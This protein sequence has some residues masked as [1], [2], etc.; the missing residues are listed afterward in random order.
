MKAT[1][2]LWLILFLCTLPV[3]FGQTPPG[4]AGAVTA[5]SFALATTGQSTSE[6]TASR[7]SVLSG[8]ARD[9][10][11]YLS[12]DWARSNHL[13]WSWRSETMSGGDYANTAEI[14]FLALSWLAAY[15][16][17]QPWQPS[18][19]ETEAEVAAILDQLRAWQTG[20]QT[21]RP[22]GP[23]AYANSVF[24][25]WYWI[26][27]DPPVVSGNPVDHL[28]PSIDNAWLAASLIV[29]R[30]YALVHGHPVLQE[31]ADAI[32]Q[33]MDFRLWYH[34]DSH[35]FTW[36]DVEEP[37]GGFFADYYS[38]ENRIINFM[39]RALGQM[40]REEYKAS[41]N[42]LIRPEGVYGDVTVAAMAWDGSYFTYG[43]PALF[44]REM[45]TAYG[46]N[47][48]LPAAQAQVAYAA[49]QG[50]AAWGLS[51]CYDVGEGGYVQQGAPPAAVAEP[52][53]RPG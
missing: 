8:L 30:E 37:Q 36:G 23:N 3:I 43:G 27:W 12:S 21:Q 31:K 5:P 19:E 9:T 53:T 38:N 29:I 13:P 41:L 18:W 45:E 2:F 35:L 52:E 49:N 7:D 47:T 24:Y 26:G 34:P 25:Q 16:M 46:A 40:T 10:W 44:I 22:H 6:L 42:A 20:S 39:A 15:D 17:A 50:Y 1:R 28:V 11:T 33:D 32:L 14:G 48:I 51:D 4:L